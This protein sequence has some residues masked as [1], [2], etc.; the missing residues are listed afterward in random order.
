[1][2]GKDTSV[3][4]D[5]GLEDM[6]LD[7]ATAISSDAGAVQSD[8]VDMAND[9]LQM[10]DNVET[11]SK[12]DRLLELLKTLRLVTNG[13]FRVCVFARY[14][15]TATYLESALSEHHPRVA[16]LTGNLPLSERE[17]I[18]AQ[19]AQ[20]GGILIATDAMSTAIPEVAAVIFYDLA[21]GSCR[22]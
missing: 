18:V 5:Y 8:F 6:V 1:M 10:L 22:A 7:D 19:F 16:T 20:S 17:Q 4:N 9:L 21:F 13:N 3:E 11:D 12:F 2:H 14:V 15:D